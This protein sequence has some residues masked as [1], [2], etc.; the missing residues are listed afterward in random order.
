M[1]EAQA[2]SPLALVGT[3]GRSAVITSVSWARRLVGLGL[4]VGVW[5]L[6]AY[7][8]FGSDHLV[9]SPQQAVVTVFHDP[10]FSLWPNVQTTL[11]EAATG[12]VWGNLIAIGLALA[13]VQLPLV[14][15]A[16]LRVALTVYCMPLF[17][18]GPVLEVVTNGTTTQSLLAGA[19]VNFTTLIGCLVGLRS[20]DP[21]ALDM[22]KAYGGGR[23]RQLTKV[24]IK[25]ALPA[26]FAGLAI[27]G[28]AA[29][30]GAIVGEYIGAP[31][32]LGVA[33]ISASENENSRRTFAIALVVTAI[34]GTAYF[35][36]FTIGRLVT[37][38]AR[39]ARPR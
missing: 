28:P 29:M 36:I 37:P 19:S 10:G 6:L 13:F 20:A 39:D 2:T 22:V 34:A 9:P 12:F 3:R 38:W 24:R 27:S 35:A 1:V 14:E 11:G 16:L 15:T 31:Q 8:V 32:G 17:A 23:W 5:E 18:V 4:L 7:T 26:A 33:L 30:L 25:A 21:I